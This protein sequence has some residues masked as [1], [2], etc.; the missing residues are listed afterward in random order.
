MTL[1]YQLDLDILPLDLHAKI[2]VPTSV[3]SGNTHI[4]THI[5][6]RCQNYYARHVRDMSVKMLKM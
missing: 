1:A 2:Q 4:D 5:E 6:T 3:E